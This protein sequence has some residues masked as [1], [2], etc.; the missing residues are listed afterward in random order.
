[1]KLRMIAATAALALSALCANA[2]VDKVVYGDDNRLDI[3][4]VTNPTHLKLAKATAA[5][6]K[7]YNVQDM[8]SGE[9]KLSGGNLN[10]CSDEKF[11]GQLTAAFCSGFLVN[12]EGK[13]YMVTAGH[14]ISNQSAC[15]GIKFVF[16]YAV[17]E[18]GQTEHNVATSSVYSCKTLVDRQLNRFDSNDYAVVELD[19]VV[20][21]RDALSFR[22]TGKVND[23][24]EILVIGH[25]SGLP[26]KVAG[27][28]YVRDNGPSKYFA[29]NL[30]TFGGNSGSAVFNAR[31][32]E[33]EGILVRGHNDYTYRTGP[34]GRSCKAP[35]Y[36]SMDGCRGEDVTRTTSIEFFQ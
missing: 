21:D 30:D 34:D 14:C 33:V 5:L 17:S 3:F 13:Q 19:R 1:M 10:V 25:P 12:H 20:T 31:T 4:E 8:R 24:E 28:A 9:S 32:G 36:C 26:T 6:V 18:A 7:S 23:G 22:T 27:D 2:S 35:E 29:T 11:D 15:E 16:D